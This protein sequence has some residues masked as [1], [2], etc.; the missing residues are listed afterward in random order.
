VY[1]SSSPRNHCFS[2]P[3]S[4]PATPEDGSNIIS[5]PEV[6]ELLLRVRF[7]NFILVLKCYFGRVNTVI[8]SEA[9]RHR[10]SLVARLVSTESGEQADRGISNR[11]SQGLSGRA[12]SFWMTMILKMSHKRSP[13]GAV[14]EHT[15]AVSIPEF[16]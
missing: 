8:N 4:N 2:N 14:S 13:P 9:E 10:I 15:F 6:G 11:A 12:H 16:F 7:Q 1:D 3:V 5:W